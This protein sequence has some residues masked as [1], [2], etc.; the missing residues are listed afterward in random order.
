[1]RGTCQV[2]K[3]S[4]ELHLVHDGGITEEDIAE[5]YVLACCSR[6]VGGVEVAV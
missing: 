1:M 5:G 3:I 6:P 4:G 2:R